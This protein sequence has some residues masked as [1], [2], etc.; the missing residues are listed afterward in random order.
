MVD[1]S[2]LPGELLAPSAALGGFGI[3]YLYY[4]FVYRPVA[5]EFSGHRVNH[6]GVR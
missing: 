5:S 1:I 2:L 6:R 4:S 3:F